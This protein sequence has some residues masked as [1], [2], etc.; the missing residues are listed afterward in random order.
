MRD[1]ISEAEKGNPSA[2]LALDVYCYRIRKYIGAYAAA[3]GGLD[4]II[5]TAGIGENSPVVRKKSCENLEFLG[6]TIDDAKNEQASSS[7]AKEIQTDDSEVK[8]FAIRTNEELVIALDTKRVIQEA[9]EKKMMRK[10]V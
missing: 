3:L 9:R 7:Q 1:I 5:F 6:I 8:V 2:A 10:G 4:A